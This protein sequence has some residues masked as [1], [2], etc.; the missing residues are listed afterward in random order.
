MWGAAL[1]IL[2]VSESSTGKRSHKRAVF[3]GIDSLFFLEWKFCQGKESGK[4][5]GGLN[6]PVSP[7]SFV[8][9]G[10]RSVRAYAKASRN[11]GTLSCEAE[12]RGLLSRAKGRAGF[13]L[14]KGSAK[15]T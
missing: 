11:N 2:E 6:P 10:Q 4:N 12:E 9:D 5:H 14:A 13:T 1:P 3:Y 15:E 7:A 8:C